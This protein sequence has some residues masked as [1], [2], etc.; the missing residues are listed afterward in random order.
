MA[1]RADRRLHRRQPLNV[2]AWV[3]ANDQ[4]PPISCAVENLSAGGARLVLAPAV[5][6][7]REFELEIP[8]LDLRVEA[9]QVWRQGEHHGVRFV[10]PQ[11]TL[12]T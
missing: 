3:R 1:E 6:L 2:S 9:H 11:H 10:W 8:T 5:E 12:W 7:P 4:V